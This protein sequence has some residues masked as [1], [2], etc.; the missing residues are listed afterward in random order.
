MFPSSYHTLTEKNLAD[1]DSLLNFKGTPL[2]LTTGQKDKI[3]NLTGFASFKVDDND[4]S[5]NISENDR[6]VSEKTGRR[7]K[8]SAENANAIRKTLTLS[9]QQQDNITAGFTR[10]NG[11][12]VIISDEDGSGQISAGDILSSKYLSVGKTSLTV[13]GAQK[14]LT[15]TKVLSEGDANYINGTYGTPLNNTTANMNKT[16]SKM[17]K[18]HSFLEYPKHIL[19]ADGSGKI[20]VGDTVV[21]GSNAFVSFDDV[22]RPRFPVSYHTLTQAH[23]DTLNA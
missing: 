16:I 8:L 7:F 3:R 10:L 12:N 11:A 17:L 5:N 14:L 21:V 9:Q 1:V 22:H 6:V 4:L 15:F 23:I 13:T 2:T 19:D 18:L 20:S